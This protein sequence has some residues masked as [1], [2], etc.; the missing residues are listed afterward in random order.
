MPKILILS[1]VVV[2][3]GDDRGG[4]HVPRAGLPDVPRDEARALVNAGRA[5]YTNRADD[6]NKAGANTATPEMLKAA[7]RV[8][9]RRG[10]AAPAAPAKPAK[11]AA[12][13]AASSDAP[14]QE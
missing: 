5:L 6:P 13:Q 1:P 12:K 11:G 8:R 7:E 9:Q 3:F 2:N 10:E 14:P 4:V